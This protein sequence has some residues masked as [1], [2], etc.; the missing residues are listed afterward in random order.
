MIKI[1]RRF[2]CS[3]SDQSNSGIKWGEYSVL[4]GAD[5]TAVETGSANTDLIIASQPT[6]QITYA[7]GLARA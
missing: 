5:G 3:P 2:N 6:L 4:A 1:G 7:A